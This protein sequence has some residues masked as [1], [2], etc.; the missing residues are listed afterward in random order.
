MADT[1][2]HRLPATWPPD[3][4]HGRTCTGEHTMTFR[5]H[6]RIA[7]QQACCCAVFG[8][9]TLSYVS[10]ISHSSP[11]TQRSAESL[12]LIMPH[13]KSSHGPRFSLP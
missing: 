11:K 8:D 7:G 4:Y 6:Q 13:S 2:K 1:R 10:S 3:G 9:H 12:P 5:T